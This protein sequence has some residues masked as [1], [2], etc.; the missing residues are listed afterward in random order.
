MKLFFKDGILL[1]KGEDYKLEKDGY[2]KVFSGDREVY[3]TTVELP[4]GSTVKH[5]FYTK[6]KSGT[7]LK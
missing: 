2:L 4:E 5:K 6:L 7:V 1:I 3:I